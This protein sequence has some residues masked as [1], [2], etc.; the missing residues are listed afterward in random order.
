MHAARGQETGVG[1]ELRAADLQKGD[2]DL[3][4]QGFEDYRLTSVV[5][6]RVAPPES[7]PPAGPVGGGGDSGFR[8]AL[9]LHAQLQETMPVAERV[10]D[11][12]SRVRVYASRSKTRRSSMVSDRPWPR[13]ATRWPPTRHR[14]AA[15]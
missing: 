8:H 12:S 1:I 3:N 4:W 10:Y 2:D 5:Y 6:I 15:G 14:G 13:A 9:L 11:K 7:P